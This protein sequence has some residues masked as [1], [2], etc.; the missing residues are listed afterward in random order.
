MAK[1]KPAFEPS[2]VVSIMSRW[3]HRRM[4]AAIGYPH[5]SPGFSEK[6]TGGYNHSEPHDYCGQD[7]SDLEL[8][9]DRMREGSPELFAAFWMHYL[10]WS[11]PGLVSAGCPFGN[12]TYYDR[13]H[14]AHRH[15]AQLMGESQPVTA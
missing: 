10:P 13:L 2:W 5:K 6:T 1:K 4:N 12:S 11:A 9:I 8:A 3:V 7:F 15:V 14:R